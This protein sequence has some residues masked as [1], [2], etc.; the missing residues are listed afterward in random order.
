[1]P[2]LNR[3]PGLA[4]L[5]VWCRAGGEERDRHD[6]ARLAS[7]CAHARAEVGEVVR[8]ARLAGTAAGIAVDDAAVAQ[9]PD[10]VVESGSGQHI[11]VMLGARYVVEA[12]CVRVYLG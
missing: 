3:V 6:L 5:L 12:C 11:L 8:P 7:G 2:R 1:M 9:A 10:V 4:H